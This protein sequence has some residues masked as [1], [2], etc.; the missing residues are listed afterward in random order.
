MFDN[1]PIPKPSPFPTRPRDSA[2]W[3]P[4]Q[5]IHYN[6]MY[7]PQRRL[8]HLA[9]L[10]VPESDIELRG[11]QARCRVCPK[12]SS[13]GWMATRQ[14]STHVSTT[15]HRQ[16][17]RVAAERQEKLRSSRAA[18]GPSTPVP[19]SRMHLP[20]QYQILYLRSHHRAIDN[21]GSSGLGI[22]RVR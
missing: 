11:T 6:G 22:F 16:W 10:G 21:P 13:D 20:I 8:I 15:K 17:A 19:G 5:K 18:A 12:T 7:F 4:K 2:M 9:D 3:R 14:L 1:D